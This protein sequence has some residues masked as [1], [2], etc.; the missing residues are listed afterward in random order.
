MTREGIVIVR[1][2]VL[3]RPKEGLLGLKDMLLEQREQ[4]ALGYGLRFPRGRGAFDE[5]VA[6]IFGWGSCR[7]R[8]HGGDP[9]WDDFCTWL[10]V[11]GHVPP[12]G[13]HAGLLRHARGN[14]DA[15]IA[16]FLELITEFD[17]EQ[18][19]G[20]AKRRI[21]DWRRSRGETLLGSLQQPP[22]A[23]W[24]GKQ[25]ITLV[26]ELLYMK[27][28]L[29]MG[30]GLWFFTGSETL[31]AFVAMLCGW[32]AFRQDHHEREPEW[33]Q[34]ERWLQERGYLPP[35]GWRAHLLDEARG[36]EV[37][38]VKRFLEWVASFAGSPTPEG[39]RPLAGSVQQAAPGSDSGESD[40]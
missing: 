14:H 7:E 12:E 22:P 36:D 16:K 24:E 19:T 20:T 10:R 23:E 30:R 21:E 1:E 26:D 38:A 35:Q 5:L 28:L 40:A 33:E 6:F 17:A 34:F 27:K 37:A 4:L 32:T 25:R 15:A 39:P 9:E 3:P 31:D 29:D 2:R 13:W 8:N 11:L 18:K